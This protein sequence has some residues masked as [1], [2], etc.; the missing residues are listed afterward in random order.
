MILSVSRR[1]DI[2]AFYSDW[3][4]KRL[5]EGYVCVRNPMYPKQVSRIELNP[6]TVDVIVFWSKNP[7][8]MLSKL[9]ALNEY[10]F[11]FQYTLNPYGK[12]IET[13]LPLIE[14]RIQTFID[15]SEQIGKDR[16]IWRYDP[17]LITNEIGVEFHIDMFDKIASLLKNHTTSVVISI[18]DNYQKIRKR[19][20]AINS[21]SITP[22]EIEQIAVA[23][24]KISYMYGLKISS[25]AED[26][27]LRPF[28]INPGKC[29]DDQLISKLLGQQISI[30]K[31][32]NQ[33]GVCGCVESIEI[34]AYNTCLHNCKYCYANYDEEAVEERYRQHDVNSPFLYGNGSSDDKITER[35]FK[36][37]K[38]QMSQL[39]LF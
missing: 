3:F 35:K 9:D 29:I 6:D 10:E 32:K 20:E 23:F 34:G 37:Y 25:C 14:E 7:K 13:N 11:Y 18:L 39:T 33:R 17:I 12:D 16:V 5:K 30:P 26:I 28:G 21:F 24:K 1:T 15:L 2:P 22:S 38:S 4:I 8:V 27:D 31:D 19:M 36:I